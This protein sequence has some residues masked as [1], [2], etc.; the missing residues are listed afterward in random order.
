MAKKAKNSKD[1]GERS[2][3]QILA[4]LL[5]RGY[6]VLLPFGDNQRYDLVVDK[7]GKFIRVQCKTGKMR[8]GYICFPT[9]SCANHC[10]LGRR[11][12]RGQADFFGVYC[13]ANDKV[14]LV[15]VKSVGIN[16]AALR[17]DPP[18]TRQK[19]G[20]RYAKKYEF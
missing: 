8:E 18:K 20:I 17:I 15:P 9:A 5:K 19:K 12:Y 3:A 2:E 13:P 14:Y 4:R 7:A 11:D 10:G 16:A 1:V 6:T